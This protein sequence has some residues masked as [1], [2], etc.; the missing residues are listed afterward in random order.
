MRVS[1]NQGHYYRHQAAGLFYFAD[2]RKQDTPIYGNSQN[3]SREA[4][5]NKIPSRMNCKKEP[6]QGKPPTICRRLFLNAH[7]LPSLADSMGNIYISYDLQSKFL[8][9]QKDVDPV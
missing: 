1:K 3:L 2:T 5:S 8:V 9:D 4:P 7:V 6:D